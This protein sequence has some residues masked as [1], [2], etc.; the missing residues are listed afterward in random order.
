VAGGARDHASAGVIDGL[1]VG[2]GLGGG[3]ITTAELDADRFGAVG[4]VPRKRGSVVN[5]SQARAWAATVA[6]GSSVADNASAVSRET[7]KR[8]R[9]RAPNR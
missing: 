7:R 2:V 3:D 8:G 9:M 5:W 6:V 4:T 1:Q